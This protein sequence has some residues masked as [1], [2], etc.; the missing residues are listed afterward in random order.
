LSKQRKSHR[1]RNPNLIAAIVEASNLGLSIPEIVEVFW[2]DLPK[3]VRRY[4][5]AA[6]TYV[7]NTLKIWGGLDMIERALCPFEL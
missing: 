2:F 6:R 4:D 3:R 1:R 5:A 7:G